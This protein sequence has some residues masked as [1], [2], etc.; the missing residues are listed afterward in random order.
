MLKKKKNEFQ[1]LANI[2]LSNLAI[3]IIIVVTNIYKALTENRQ[4]FISFTVQKEANKEVFLC[5]GSFVGNRIGLCAHGFLGMVSLE[6]TMHVL[7][8]NFQ[9][10]S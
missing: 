10:C 4:F 9:I 8:G 7:W 5:F 3:H 6:D 1:H 2:Q